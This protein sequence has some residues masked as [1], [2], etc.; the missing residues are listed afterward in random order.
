MTRVMKMIDVSPNA[1]VITCPLLC[2]LAGVYHKI[3]I[4]LYENSSG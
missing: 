3:S 1:A 4:V 2:F